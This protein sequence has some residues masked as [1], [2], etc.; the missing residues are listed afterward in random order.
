VIERTPPVRVIE[1]TPQGRVIE[2]TI[3]KCEKGN[4]GR[5]AEGLRIKRTSR[6]KPIGTGLRL[7]LRCAT[8]KKK[9][10]KKGG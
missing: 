7:G 9:K 6:P 4:G 8:K 1:R 2:R 5:R 10:K 3:T